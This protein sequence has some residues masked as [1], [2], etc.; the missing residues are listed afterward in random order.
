LTRLAALRE[1]LIFG[2][3]HQRRRQPTL[4]LSFAS[5]AL[6]RVITRRS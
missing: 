2:L 4:Y 3:A 5:A 1:V 6:V